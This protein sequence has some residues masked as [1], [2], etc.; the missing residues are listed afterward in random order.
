ML[1][2]VVEDSD[3]LLSPGSLNGTSVQSESVLTQWWNI[4]ILKQLDV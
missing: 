1:K 3:K 4:K 2:N